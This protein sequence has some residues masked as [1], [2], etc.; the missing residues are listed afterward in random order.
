MESLEMKSDFWA[1]KTVALTG[2]TGFKGG[3]LAHFLFSLGAKVYGFS[4]PP[5][6]QTNFMKRLK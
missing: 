3:W 6:K 1:N 5:S 2:H 4:L